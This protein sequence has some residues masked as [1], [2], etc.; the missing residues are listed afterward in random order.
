MY[1]AELLLVTS[2]FFSLVRYWPEFGANDKE[3]IT[4]ADLLSHQAGLASFESTISE[5]DIKVLSLCLLNLHL[6]SGPEG[7][8]QCPMEPPLPHRGP[9]VAFLGL[10]LVSEAS[11]WPSEIS[12]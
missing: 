8:Q 1:W 6:G 3:N 7:G 5:D 9:R 11:K 12:D 10:R 4:L 2:F